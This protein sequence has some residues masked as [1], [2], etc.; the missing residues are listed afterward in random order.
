MMLCS[1]VLVC[2]WPGVMFSD[3]PDGIFLKFIWHMTSNKTQAKFKKGGYMPIWTV[4]KTHS[5]PYSGYRYVPLRFG[6]NVIRRMGTQQQQFGQEYF[7]LVHDVLV[8]FM[9]FLMTDLT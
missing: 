3:R 7:S 9:F 4:G 5:A 1:K 8:L 2:I 6:R